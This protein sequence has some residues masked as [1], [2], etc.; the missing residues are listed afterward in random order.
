[1][2]YDGDEREPDPVVEE[3]G[4]K[5][6]EEED[7]DEDEDEDNGGK[8]LKKDVLLDSADDEDLLDTNGALL[9][10]L[11][12][13]PKDN[14]VSSTYAA[15][16][17]WVGAIGLKT[18]E[19]GALP[20]SVPPYDELHLDWVYGYSARLTRGAVQYSSSGRILY[21][22]ATVAVLLN[23]HNRTQS[24]ACHHHDDV[25]ALDAHPIR[26]LAATGHRGRG[27][28][29]VCV[30]SATTG[31][32]VR[33]LSCGVV[34]GISALKFS[35]DGVHLAVACQDEHHSVLLFDWERAGVV[36]GRAKGG[37]KILC[38]SFSLST[39]SVR[40]LQGGVGHFQLLEMTGATL[41]AKT[42]QYGGDAKKLN[43]LCAAGLPLS[44]EGGGN[45]FIVGLSNGS[46]GVIARGEKLISNYVSLQAKAIT[47]IWV[48]GVNPA[49]GGADGG[50]VSF[51]VVTGG[52]D[53]HIKVL[54]TE[55][56]P[57]SEY[58]MYS[59][60]VSYGL[61]PLGKLRG[62]KS[63]C[64]DKDGRKILFGTSGGEIGEISIDDGSDLNLGPL[65]QG[66][67]RDQ[68]YGLA[69][70]PIRQECI[71]VGDDRVLRVWSLE[72]RVVLSSLDLPDVARAVCYSPTGQIVA[73]GL[74]GIVRGAGRV[75]RAHDGKLVVISFL[76]GVLR[77]VFETQDARGPVTS[78]IFSP[79]GSR[80]FLGSLDGK[81]YV[82]DV[83]DNFNLT[84]TLDRHAAGVV[85][86]D[87]SVSGKLL[88]SVDTE[89]EILLW[90]LDEMGS[91][92]PDTKRL[93]TYSTEQWYVRQ[94]VLSYDSIGVFPAVG[95]K[96]S[97]VSTICR[98]ADK[99]LMC[100]GDVNGNLHLLK[101]PSLRPGAPFKNYRI[102]SM[103]GISK[104]VFSVKDQFL[105]SLGKEDKTLCQ[106][107]VEKVVDEVAVKPSDRQQLV[108]TALISASDVNLALLKDVA[109]GVASVSTVVNTVNFSKDSAANSAAPPDI[110]VQ[111]SAV[112][113]L[114]GSSSSAA[115]RSALPLAYYSGP[116]DI[117][118]VAG[119][120]PLLIS[121]DKQ[122]Q[123]LLTDVCAGAA[124]SR[125]IGV[126]ALSSDQRL[127][128]LGE[129][130]SVLEALEAPTALLAKLTVLDAATG[131]VLSTLPGGVLGG[132]SAACFSHDDHRI[133][134]LGADKLSSLSVYLSASKSWLDAVLVY[135]GVT[136]SRPSFVLSFIM[137]GP[138][139][140]GSSN[141]FQ[142]ATGGEASLK[143]WR[144]QGG[145]V[146][147]SSQAAEYKDKAVQSA[148]ITSALSVRINGLITGDAAGS[149]M[150][151]EGS[152]CTTV[153]RSVHDSAVS[154][155]CPVRVHRSGGEGETSSSGA[156]FI[157]ASSDKIIVWSESC[158]A[159]AEYSLSS[160]LASVDRPHHKNVFVTSLSVD[161]HFRR[162]LLTTSTSL[163]LEVAMDSQAVL[164]VAE[165]HATGKFKA[166][167]A[168]PVLPSFLVSGTQD[169]ILRLWDL[170]SRRVIE[171]H[172][173]GTPISYLCFRA[174]GTSI[175]VAVLSAG[176]AGAAILIMGFESKEK[177][178]FSTSHRIN[179]VGQGSINALRFSPD[180]TF[181]AA[182]SEDRTIYL[183]DTRNGYKLRGSIRAHFSAVTGL[184][185]SL[186]GNR[187][188]RKLS[189]V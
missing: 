87:I 160:Y 97:E 99:R 64:V 151:W 156:G 117:F 121:K 53:G 62:I 58:S 10:H 172:Q 55:F 56:S 135:S 41:F 110:T 163:V 39:T 116:G 18:S 30:W 170:P 65:V 141:P 3:G 181:L 100:S 159:I 75:P 37:K 98:S 175:A 82:Y 14:E 177:P 77:V 157:S 26:N 153:M 127:V 189:V 137:Q 51:K 67:C 125:D 132:V 59:G 1:M 144:L 80:L 162:M 139:G 19:L 171:T 31:Q 28:I 101:Y 140:A 94:N 119:A 129:K 179:N 86:M 12:P 11:A 123:R 95:G 103:G 174:E 187:N 89:A 124:S 109:S 46:I 76:Q 7:E 24:Y 112:L 106:W 34:G 17:P 143:F 33:R 47:S 105:L 54:D 133:A 48:T 93:A 149:L 22:A 4:E 188:R 60:K 115:Q 161:A 79:D 13:L 57:I 91:L 8:K 186:S 176:D 23:K 32:A 147:P 131:L 74:G 165:G 49:D 88:S 45:E 142:I 111:L 180:E 148:V 122:R 102:H 25:T 29:G 158:Q 154:A 152:K 118:T 130:A 145:A 155:L 16:A 92:I 134:C 21:P 167:A 36:K 85:S 69:A 178:H 70:H 185:F 42:G 83:L 52:V 9:A 114:G 113:G 40:L 6:E 2:A 63:I 168:H 84:H 104:V 120:L 182:A 44:A 166:L 38:L 78:I 35:P 73:V 108:P 20:A 61:H 96:Y 136:D 184:D 27:D 71:T 150:A 43:V 169:G 68:C 81:I 107:R 126:V 72:K 50:E 183:Y 173:L 138:E 90:D 146:N 164:L 66:H 128:C 5:E 15:Q